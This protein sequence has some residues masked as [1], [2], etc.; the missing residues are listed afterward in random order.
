MSEEIR[1]KFKQEHKDDDA[2]LSAIFSNSK[3]LTVEAPAGYGKTKT[4]I[5]KIAFDI[6]TKKINN[7]KKVLVLT[8]SVNAAHK[9]KKDVI[10]QLP[11]LLEQYSDTYTENLVKNKVQVTNYHGFCRKVLGKY[12]YYIHEN[13]KNID[14]LIPLTNNND[15]SLTKLEL[16]IISNFSNAVNSVDYQNI[17]K[18]REEYLKLVVEKLI[19]NNCITYDSIILLTEYLFINYPTILN[20]YQKLFT[21][22]IIDEFQDTNYLSWSLLKL[23]IKQDTRVIFFGDSLQKIYGFIGAIP[24]LF[25]EAAEMFGTEYIHLEKN[26]RFMENKEMLLLDKS[27]RRIARNPTLPLVDEQS[28]IYVNL[29]ETQRDEAKGIIN[30]LKNLP[31]KQENSK[32]SI[33]VRQRGKNLE[34]ILNQLESQDIE[35]FNGLNLR[36]EDLSYIKFNDECLSKFIEFMKTKHTLTKKTLVEFYNI[37]YEMYKNI[38]SDNQPLLKLLKIFIHEFPKEQVWKQSTMEQRKHSIINFFVSRNL[39]NY[40]EYVEEN[41]IV[42]TVYG[43]KGLEWDYVI[44]PDVEK[45]SFP[46]YHGMCKN[47]SFKRW[48]Q[49]GINQNNEAQLIDELGVFYVAVT[50]AKKQVYLTASEKNAFG[51]NVNRSCFLNLLRINCKKQSVLS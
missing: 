22:I 28:N 13:L 40:M 33:I 18:F 30:I 31:V 45:D 7:H 37:V 32:V 1:E 20:F 4:L 11:S 15:I 49:L 23:L 24:N 16:E 17:K 36:D 47:C 10:L 41:L 38:E 3:K 21:T 39:K 48:C 5:S 6:A 34:E 43:A 50:R 29:F 25:D 26:Y 9:V 14:Q 2:Q 44:I 42:T 46:N 51:Y 27:I 19:P 35:F 12:G 8:F